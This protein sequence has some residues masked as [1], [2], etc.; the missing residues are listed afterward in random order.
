[1]K[2]EKIQTGKIEL[3]NMERKINIIKRTVDIAQ[4]RKKYVYIYI[5]I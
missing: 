4:E 5:H 1:M 3:C 2:R